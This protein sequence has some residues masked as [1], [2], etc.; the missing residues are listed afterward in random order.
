VTVR[1][2]QNMIYSI[3]W[4]L[5]ARV[6]T[7]LPVGFR[8]FWIL[9]ELAGVAYACAHRRHVWRVNVLLLEAVPRYFGE[10]RVVHDVFAAAVQIAQALGQVGGDEF[11]QQV[12]R[13]WVD[14]G[15][16]FDARLEDVFVNLHGRAA[17]PEGREAAQ[18][19]EDEDAE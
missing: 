12:V 11:L 18:H 4:T 13:V 16:V 14:V 5:D 3:R 8:L 15:W 19:L 9:I 1:A 10:P 6:V 2:R 7:S 17:V